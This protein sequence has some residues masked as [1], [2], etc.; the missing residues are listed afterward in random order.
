LSDTQARPQ[1]QTRT[2]EKDK[3]RHHEHDLDQDTMARVSG[4]CAAVRC[5][6]RGLR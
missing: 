2:D 5:P 4:A 3:D 6:D 1:Q